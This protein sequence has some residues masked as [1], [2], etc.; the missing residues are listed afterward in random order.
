MK[1]EFKDDAVADVNID[2]DPFYDLTMGGYIKPH[3]ILKD[4]ELAH[5]V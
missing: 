4:Q 3:D 1:F 5:G 2:G